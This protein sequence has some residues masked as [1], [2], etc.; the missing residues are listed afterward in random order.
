MAP[1]PDKK[2][3]RVPTEAETAGW[4]RPDAVC[5]LLRWRASGKPYDRGM[6]VADWLP[7]SGGVAGPGA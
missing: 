5:C 2:T 4:Q 3:G 7:G 1:K 6:V